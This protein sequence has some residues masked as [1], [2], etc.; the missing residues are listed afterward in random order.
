M[1]NIHPVT[2]SEWAAYIN[3][4]SGNQLRD[5]AIAANDVAFVRQLES[6]GAKAKTIGTILTM[7]ALRLREDHQVVPGRASGT[8]LDYSALLTSREALEAPSES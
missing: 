6:E 7:F 5:A 2:L 1:S 4:L 3:S 8:Y